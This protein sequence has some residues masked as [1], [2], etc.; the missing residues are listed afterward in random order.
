MQPALQKHSGKHKLGKSAQTS[1]WVVPNRRWR[2][3]HPERAG[4]PWRGANAAASAWLVFAA[5]QQAAIAARVQ[6]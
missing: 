3:G 6:T 5:K 1:F 2:P 4:R